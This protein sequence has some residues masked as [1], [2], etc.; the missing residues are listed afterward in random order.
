MV[1]VL[2]LRLKLNNT[3]FTSFRE[4]ISSL[5]SKGTT[6]Y[7]VSGGFREMIEPLVADVLSIPRENVFAN[8]LLFD[9]KGKRNL[10]T[11]H[12][13]FHAYIGLR[14]L[15]TFLIY[16]EFISRALFRI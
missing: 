8:K 12:F 16:Y 1:Q 15:L 11:G 3:S 2:K 6:V 14:S 7:L 9:D 13:F 10:L 5:A 4:V